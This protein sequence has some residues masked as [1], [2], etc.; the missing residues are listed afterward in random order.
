MPVERPVITTFAPFASASTI[1]AEPRYALAESTRSRIDGERL[2]GLHVLELVAGGEQFI[3]ARQQ[4]VARH[5]ADPIFPDARFARA[6]R[7]NRGRARPG[8]TPPAF[9]ITFTPRSATPASSSI[10]PTKSARIPCFGSRS[11]CF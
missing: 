2:A 10:A 3:E 7:A 4:I 6:D 5:D 9:A 1:G 8:F 11:F